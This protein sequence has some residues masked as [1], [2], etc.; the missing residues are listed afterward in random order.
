LQ[1]TVK[2]LQVAPDRQQEEEAA[3][4]VFPEVAVRRVP[5]EREPSRRP[6]QAVR[7][8]EAEHRPTASAGTCG[9]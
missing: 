4:R 8:E 7:R 5:V 3:E 2:Y 9:G 6:V 1:G